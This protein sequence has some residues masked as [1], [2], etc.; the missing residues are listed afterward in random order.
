LYDVKKLEEISSGFSQYCNER[1][2][3]CVMAVD[4]WVCHTRCPNLKE[5]NNQI[6]FRNRKSCWGL[7]CFAGCDY[8][9]R[10]LM[11]STRCPGSIND[12]IAWQMTSIFKDVVEKGFLPK[13]FYIICDEA[14]SATE[15]VLSPFAGCHIGKWR[16]SFNYHL[17]CM[18]Q[19]IER[20]FGILTRR[21][22]IFWRPLAC[23]ISRWNIVMR[24][25]AKL[26]NLCIDFGQQNFTTGTMAEDHEESDS[27]EIF[28]NEYN[29]ENIGL[30]PANADNSSQ[31][32]L[33][34]TGYLKAQGWARPPHA[35]N[36][37][38]E[39]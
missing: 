32:R 26:H 28:M 33:N 20:A 14:L 1:M 38:K 31:R 25:C 16:D 5:V 35:M 24:V 8:K 12:C 11:F 6:C 15:T 13:K 4:G 29:R 39:N 18:R 10:F 27:A 34:I 3:G 7:V 22:G 19:C 23:D 21:W 36:N 37:S 9:S 2:K 30:F 17:S